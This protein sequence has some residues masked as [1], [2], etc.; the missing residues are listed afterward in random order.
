M[1]L[2][3][4]EHACLV[5]QKTGQTLVID[6]GVFTMPLDDLRDVVGIV[7]THEHPDH[8]TPGH[9]RRIIEMNPDA[10]IVGPAGVAAAAAEFAD[11]FTIDVVAAGDAIEIAGFSLRFFGG[12]HAEIH[13][14]IPIIDNVG[15]LVDNDLYYPGDSYAIPEGITVGTLAVPSGAPWLK[16]SEAMDYV[17]AVAPRRAFPVHEMTLSVAGKGMHNDRLKAMTEKNGGTFFVLE[18]GESLGL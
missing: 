16:I 3:K 8:W 18:P 10:R 15:V 6:P 12:R 2:T 1:N 14:S 13:S 5:L 11:E 4:H 7:I 9:L 17:D